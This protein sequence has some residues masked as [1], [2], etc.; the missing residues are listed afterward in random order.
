MHSRPR[1][2]NR[3]TG[4]GRAGGHFSE[5][6]PFLPVTARDPVNE[7]LLPIK[8][9]ERTKK[10]SVFPYRTLRENVRETGTAREPTSHRDPAYSPRDARM[11]RI[12]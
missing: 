6:C 2:L 1:T 10:S 4:A 9:H 3:F 5:R 12:P 11:I 7:Q 8:L